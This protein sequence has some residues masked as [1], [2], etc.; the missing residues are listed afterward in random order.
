MARRSQPP[1]SA[2]ARLRQAANAEACGAGVMAR[3]IGA[4]A[5]RDR[6][7]TEYVAGTFQ[8]RYSPPLRPNSRA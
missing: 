2:I 8:T 1:S 7:A 3:L 6:G 5:G 4:N